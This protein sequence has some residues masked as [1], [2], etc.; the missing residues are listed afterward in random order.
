MPTIIFKE[1]EAC[2]SNCIYCDVI[3]RKKPLTIT[4]DLLHLVYERINEYL[5]D[6]PEET[7][8]IIWHGGEPLIVGVDFYKKVLNIAIATCPKTKNRIKY[9]I[10]SNLTLIT[11]EFIDVFKNM[12]ISMIGT[13][14]E[15]YK[16]IRGFGVERNSDIYNRRFFNGI[17]LLEKNEFGWGFIYVVTRKALD[18]P[19]EIFNVLSNF[20][21]RNTFD[22]HPVYSYK[23]EDKN[24]VGITPKE[25][26]DFLGIICQEWWEHKDRYPRVEPF[27]SYVE[28]YTNTNKSLVCTRSNCAYTHMYIGP[29][30]EV[31]HCGRASEWDDVFETVDIKNITIAQIFD[32]PYRK[33]L[34]ERNNILKETECKG[35]KYFYIC[36]SGCPLD[37]WNGTGDFMKKSMWCEKYFLENYFEPIT[38]LKLNSNGDGAYNE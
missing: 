23:N 18:K 27:S 10:Q 25:F 13:S 36:G 3:A 7:F 29:S 32:L 21:G 4:E 1:T 26:A 22:I 20:A 35:C 6:N 12:G 14:Y 17:E 19:L 37:G 11:Q 9:N 8:E 15:P 31:S 30:G 34:A 16:G 2:N 38:N 33:Q 24:R 5:L 28:L